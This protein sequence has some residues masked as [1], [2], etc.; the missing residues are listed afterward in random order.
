MPSLFGGGGTST[1]HQFGHQASR[2]APSGRD[3]ELLDI[4]RNALTGEL[5]SPQVHNIPTPLGQGIGGLQEMLFGGGAKTGLAGL[6]G[7]GLSGTALD[8]NALGLDTPRIAPPEFLPSPADAAES[9][10]PV[11]VAPVVKKANQL[12]NKIGRLTDRQSAKQATG[13]PTPGLDRRI[14]KLTDKQN[15]PRPGQVAA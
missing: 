6:G 7:P 14:A 9:L 15:R 10:A 1:Q 3:Q 5:T 13:A 11:R 4:L 8:R 2:H 12:N